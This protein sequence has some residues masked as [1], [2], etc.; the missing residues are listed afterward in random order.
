[1]SY[2]DDRLHLATWQQVRRWLGSRQEPLCRLAC[3]ALDENDWL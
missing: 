3:E 1:V 2:P